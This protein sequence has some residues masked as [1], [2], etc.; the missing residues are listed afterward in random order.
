MH[1]AQG[2]KAIIS[3]I[4]NSPIEPNMPIPPILLVATPLITK[5][6]G[7]IAPKFAG[8]A[9][10]CKG[11]ANEYQ[12]VSKEMHCAF[13]DAASVITSSKVDGIHLDHEQHEVLAR[14]WQ[15]K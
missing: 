5:P 1:A 10:K 13:F 14:H 7:Q 12:T 9:E 3:A 11:L 2:I 4:Q 15:N 6:K 8:G